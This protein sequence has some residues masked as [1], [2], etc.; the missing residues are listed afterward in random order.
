[1]RHS[2]TRLLTS[3]LATPASQNQSMIEAT[4]T[5]ASIF[6]TVYPQVPPFTVHSA[7]AA[8]LTT[9]ARSQTSLDL[10]N[11]TDVA[12]LAEQILFYQ[13]SPYNRTVFLRYAPEMQGNW[14]A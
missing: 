1:M 8:K 11:S 3:V 9:P 7:P 10:T 2:D 6:L 13:S 4:G 5:N 12:L 14:M